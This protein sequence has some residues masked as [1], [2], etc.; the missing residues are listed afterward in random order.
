MPPIML[1]NALM[2][3]MP[4][5][6]LICFI[7]CSRLKGV[8]LHDDRAATC[9]RHTCGMPQCTSIQK[10]SVDDSPLLSPKLR[11]HLRIQALAELLHSLHQNYKK[12]ICFVHTTAN[13]DKTS[14]ERR[15]HCSCGSS[16]TL[17]H[18]DMS[19]TPKHITSPIAP[20]SALK[21]AADL[22]R[23]V[24]SSHLAVFIK[25]QV[26]HLP[27][28]LLELLALLYQSS[29]LRESAHISV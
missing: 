10:V 4:F 6:P 19:S 13:G 22:L 21:N 16:H 18:H 14:D 15:Q 28:H 7:I 2:S 9:K 3:G 24:S 17:F 5:L 23:V 20:I 26:L 11:Q 12:K 27:H 29:N 1:C 8:K 25:L